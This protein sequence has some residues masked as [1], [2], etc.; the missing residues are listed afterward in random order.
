M[1]IQC[2][3]CGGRYNNHKPSCPIQVKINSKIKSIRESIKKDF[4]G[5]SPNIFVGRF[6]YPNINVGILSTEH[7]SLNDDPLAWVRNNYGIEQI[8]DL[9]SALI[10]SNFGSNTRAFGRKLMDISQEISLSYKPVDVE[11]NLKEK[12][13][14]RMQFTRHHMPMG[15]N[16]KVENA[17]ITEN[18]KVPTRVDKVVDDT[19]MKAADALNYLYKHELDEHYLTKLFSLGNVGTK[20]CRKIVPTRWSITAVDDAIGKGIMD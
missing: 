16:A 18:P 4:F 15:T 11:I 10:N 19:D 13:E 1:L 8:V 20:A 5:K 9:R 6:N 2:K 17:K 3:H 14:F 7:Y 12:P